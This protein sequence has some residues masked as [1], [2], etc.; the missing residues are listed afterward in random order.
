MTLTP[1]QEA[2]RCPACA[3]DPRAAPGRSCP[4]LACVCNHEQCPAYPSSRA[5]RAA[6][7]TPLPRK[8]STDAA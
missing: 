3:A 7:V 8:D 6:N 1:D 4:A 2:Q 5:A